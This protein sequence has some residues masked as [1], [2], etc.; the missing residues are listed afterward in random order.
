M[1]DPIISVS[2]RYFKGCHEK[3]LYVE[4]DFVYNSGI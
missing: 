4:G 1:L 2:R 3:A